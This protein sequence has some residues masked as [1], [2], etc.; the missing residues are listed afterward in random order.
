LGF[1]CVKMSWKEFLEEN[2]RSVCFDGYRK[3]GNRSVSAHGYSIEEL[4]GSLEYNL[5]KGFVEESQ[6]CVMELWM[7]TYYGGD[8]VVSKILDMFQERVVSWCMDP[9]ILKRVMLFRE[10]LDQD[11]ISLESLLYISEVMANGEKSNVVLN[12]GN[13]CN[14]FVEF[15]KTKEKIFADR[16][17]SRYREEWVSCVEHLSKAGSMENWLEIQK[18]VYGCKKLGELD[19]VWLEIRKQVVGLGIETEWLEELLQYY[20]VVKGMS[21]FEDS[22]RYVGYS[23]ICL[24]KDGGCF[25]QECV[26]S[27]DDYQIQDIE[28]SYSNSILWDQRAKW[29]GSKKK[30][31]G[32]LQLLACEDTWRSCPEIYN[33]MAIVMSVYD[34]KQ[35]KAKKEPKEMP[36][37]R[38]KRKKRPIKKDWSVLVEKG[39]LELDETYT[40]G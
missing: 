18:L 14:N 35:G 1:G 10:N 4:M 24:L 27:G 2:D 11:K 20:K 16:S 19:D 5:F 12:I 40:I 36:D 34:R 26:D 9:S 17:S 32:M 15:M 6:M 25:Q 28:E 31:M 37:P 22:K 33:E 8:I 7:F 38:P 23:A 21:S 13:I 29:I 30:E 3:L 39:E